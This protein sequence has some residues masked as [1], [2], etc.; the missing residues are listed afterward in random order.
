MTDLIQYTM[1]RK[2]KAEIETVKGTIQWAR[3]L[4]NERQRFLS[5]GRQA[6][7]RKNER[8]EIALYVNDCA[9]Q[10]G[11]GRRG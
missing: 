9:Y 1:Y 8:G 10:S 5:N 6:S 7:I 3:H 4:K 11:S 2:P